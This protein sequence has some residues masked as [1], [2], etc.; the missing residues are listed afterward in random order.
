MFMRSEK[1][2]ISAPENQIIVG[3]VNIVKV[4]CHSVRSFIRTVEPLD[5][6]FKRTV[7]FGGSVVVSKPNYH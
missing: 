5:H 4:V 6:L 7:L 2:I 1:V 3:T